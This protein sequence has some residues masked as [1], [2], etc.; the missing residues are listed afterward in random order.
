MATLD[1]MDSDAPTHRTHGAPGGARR[2][3]DRLRRRWTLAVGAGVAVIVCG[4]LALA[5]VRTPVTGLWW[6]LGAGAVLVVEAS[7][8]W[9]GL[10]ANR[11]TREAP[12]LPTLG[13][14]NGLTLVRGLALAAVA[15]FLLLP[16]P[17]G[18]LAWAPGALYGAAALLDQ[19]DGR[20]ARG[21]GRTTLLGERLDMAFDTVGLLVA[22][23]LAVRYGQLPVW[24]LAVSAARY[25]FLAA[26]FVRRR[27]GLPIHDL[28][29]SPVR[30]PLAGV[31]MA[32]V[33][34][35]LSPVLGPPTTTLLATVAMVPFLA[36][37]A[38]DWLAVSGRSPR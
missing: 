25:V 9:R 38:R 5:A 6:I 1:D 2:P 23:V 10:D 31:Q 15:G 30:R 8:L 32:V 16:R 34:L 27:R 3:A 29:E 18:A 19:V 13:L 24:Y 7:L 20:V 11:T 37:F 21:Y 17:V 4:A 35:A 12:L 22:P 26:L 28:P 33:A 36:G 14:A